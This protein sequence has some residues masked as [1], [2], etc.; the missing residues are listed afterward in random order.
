MQYK[1]HWF[2]QLAYLI[3]PWVKS[4]I[5][6]EHFGCVFSSRWLWKKPV[7]GADMR[8]RTW[9]RTLT[10]DAWSDHHWQ[11]RRQ[12]SAWWSLPP[13]CWCVLVVALPRWSAKRLSTHQSSWA[14]AGV[15]GTF[16]AWSLRRD[17]PVGSNL[18][19]LGQ[20]I[21]SNEPIWT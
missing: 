19:S 3:S 15:Y 9:K 12:S 14:P 21:L 16:P 11:P 5:I 7:S 1:H 8:I 2:A 17:S 6:F 18:E 4:I 10:T 20:M 13:P